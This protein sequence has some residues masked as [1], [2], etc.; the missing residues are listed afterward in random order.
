MKAVTIESKILSLRSQNQFYAAI[1]PYSYT[2][3]QPYSHWYNLTK[4][5]NQFKKPKDTSGVELLDFDNFFICWTAIRPTSARG[6]GP[7]L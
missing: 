1:Q 7:I 2:A 5:K 4:D 6:M 3:I